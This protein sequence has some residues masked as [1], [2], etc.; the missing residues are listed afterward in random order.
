VVRITFGGSLQRGGSLKYVEN[1]CS[2]ES[3]FVWSTA[4]G[5]IMTMDNLR[6]IKVIGV[7]WCCMCKRSR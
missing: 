4:L 7:E 5:N 1:Q 3:F 6:K 2:I